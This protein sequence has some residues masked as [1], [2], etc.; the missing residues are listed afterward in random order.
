MNF[1]VELSITLD[2]VDDLVVERELDVGLELDGFTLVLVVFRLFG[3]KGRFELVVVVTTVAL[4][5]L[6]ED[7]FLDVVVLGITATAATVALDDLVEDDFLDVVVLG[8]TATAATGFQRL[9]LVLV[10]D[11]FALVRVEVFLVEDLRD[12]LL[13]LDFEEKVEDLNDDAA[14]LGRDVDLLELL[15]EELFI[16][17]A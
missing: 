17:V 4:D 3:F 14:G 10:A 8:I 16:L 9:I 5:D 12:D 2:F 11:D 1:F 15:V 13:F 6:V 7:D